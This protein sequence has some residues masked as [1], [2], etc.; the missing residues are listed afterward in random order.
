MEIKQIVKGHATT[1]VSVI[2]FGFATDEQI[3]AFAMEA[4]RENRSSLF[5]TSVRIVDDFSGPVAFKV[6]VVSLHTD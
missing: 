6:A 3:T 4:A 2:N 5:G 1:R